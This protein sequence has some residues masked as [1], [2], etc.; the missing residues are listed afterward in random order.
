MI[1]SSRRLLSCEEFL[2]QVSVVRA[3]RLKALEGHTSGYDT[4]GYD[5]VL[6][7]DCRVERRKKEGRGRKRE[8]SQ[9][10]LNPI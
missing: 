7:Q 10:P 9:V 6:S 2:N 1:L 3:D 8:T 4:S 5:I